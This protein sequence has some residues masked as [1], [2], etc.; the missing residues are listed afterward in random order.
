MHGDKYDY[1]QVEYRGRS[2]KVTIGCP[3]HG[4]CAV[5]ILRHQGLFEDIVSRTPVLLT[6]NR[7][8]RLFNVKIPY[9]KEK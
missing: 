7:K 8:E 1:S 9:L 2:R 6:P 4:W 5:R 3:V